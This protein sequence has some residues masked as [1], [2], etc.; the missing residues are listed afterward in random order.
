M[1]AQDEVIRR[2]NF[3]A[4]EAVDWDTV[5]QA[6]LPRVYNFFRYRLGDDA[7]AEDLTSATF[8]KAWVKRGSYRYDRAAFSTWL[9]SIARNLVIDH[10]RQNQQT[11]SLDEQM[12]LVAPAPGVE[13]QVQM[14][15]DFV[16]LE[17]LLASLPEREQELVAFKYGAE[18]TNR[19]IARL[20]GLSE[21]NVGSILHRVVNKLRNQ[22]EAHN[23]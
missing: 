3:L 1:R 2:L 13:Q 15:Q 4:K 22:W 12:D 17:K 5:F 8:E 18:L 20:T 7:E 6:E 16:H 9:F 23:G 14:Q 19:E 11:I 21:T 10:H